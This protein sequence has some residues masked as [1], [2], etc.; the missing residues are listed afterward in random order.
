MACI[1]CAFPAS[2]A[3]HQNEQGDS[4]FWAV[5]G[6]TANM[7]LM[8]SAACNI[9]LGAWYYYL[10]ATANGNPAAVTY[11]SPYCAGSAGTA[12]NLITGLLSH[13]KGP[14]GGKGVIADMNGVNALMG[15]DNNAYQYITQIKTMFDSMVGP[16]NGKHP[17]FITLSPNP[18]QYCR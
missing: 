3:D 2:F 9:A 5:A 1:G 17:L 8:Q 6:P 10:F 16:V 7:S 12:G 14:S 11:V 4:A 15:S 18:T 13:L